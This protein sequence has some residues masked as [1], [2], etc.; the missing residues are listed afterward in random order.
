MG[1]AL[2]EADADEQVL[3]AAVDAAVVAQIRANFPFLPDR[4]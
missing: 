3:V 2:F 4:R 1:D